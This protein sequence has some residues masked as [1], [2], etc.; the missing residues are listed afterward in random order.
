[1]HWAVKPRAKIKVDRKDFANSGKMERNIYKI[2]EKV[3]EVHDTDKSYKDVGTEYEWNRYNL[4]TARC[5]IETSAEV[6]PYRAH[7]ADP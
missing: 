7:A 3:Q 4:P 1:M 5:G 6:S 2:L